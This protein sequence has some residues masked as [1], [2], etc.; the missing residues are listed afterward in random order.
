MLPN[1]SQEDYKVISSFIKE[2]S[3]EL[4]RHEEKEG[5]FVGLPASNLML[6]PIK[7]KSYYRVATG[8]FIRIIDDSIIQAATEKYPELFGNHRPEDILKAIHL[9]TEDV[10][11]GLYP[12]FEQFK[13]S[14]KNAHCYIVD[15]SNSTLTDRLLR[16]DL[17]RKIDNSEFTGGLF[18]CFKHFSTN[19]VN[20]S[21]G[22]ELVEIFHPI[23]MIHYLAIAF[24]G[25]NDKQKTSKGF[26]TM[27]EFDENYNLFFS[28]YEEKNT[29]VH[30]L[31]TA[32]K[33]AK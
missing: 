17:F 30:F 7:E 3:I 15:Y 27:V 13:E 5:S 8:F 23:R 19:G 1:L 11:P 28:F 26:T 33:Q 10:L 24:Y 12:A 14:V 25:D 29:G 2:K 21:T 6:F 22:R 31:Q 9:V 4:I 18:H 20:L 32:Y 16:V